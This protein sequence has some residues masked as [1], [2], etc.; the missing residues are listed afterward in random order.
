MKVDSTYCRRGLYQL[1]GR[2][3]II[4]HPFLKRPPAIWIWVV[5]YGS[6][7]AG[8]VHLIFKTKMF[9]SYRDQQDVFIAAGSNIGMSVGGCFPPG[10]DIK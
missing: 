3:K 2:F 8:M 7:I 4:D 6:V 9:G 1:S 10:I 5:R